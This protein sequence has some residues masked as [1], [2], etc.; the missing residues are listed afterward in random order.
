L[1]KTHLTELA[2]SVIGLNPVTGTPPNIHDPGLVPGG[3][4]SGAAA[5][6]AFRLAPV[7]VGS[8]TAG[9]VRIPAAW[10]DLVGLKTTHGLLPLDGVVPLRPGFDTVGVLSRTVEDAALLLGALADAPAP[11][12]A[13]TS[14]REVRILALEDQGVL[15][16]REGPARAASAALGRLA[17]AGAR[18]EAGAP[19]V[20]ADVNALLPAVAAGAWR[21]WGAAIEANPEVM[22]A[23][24][25]ERFRG[26]ASRTDAE[27]AAA[28]QALDRARTAWSAATAGFDAVALPTTANLPPEANAVLADHGLFAAE[29]LL[30]LR[31]ANL[32]NLL[33]LCAITLPTGVPHCGLTLMA[34]GGGDAGLL[35]LAAAVEAALR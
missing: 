2:F 28:L 16:T 18:V 12:L 34:P 9:S 1:G 4:S 19:A 17:D 25:R 27:Y 30:A 26:G 13:G 32:A 35:R 29:N 14:L 24:I 10:N 20:V 5:S 7:A 21:T 3:S 22:F 31:N 15:P 11:D 6:V 33:G 23:P 8:D